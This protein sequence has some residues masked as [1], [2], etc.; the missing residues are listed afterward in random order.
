MLWAFEKCFG[1]TCEVHGWSLPEVDQSHFQWSGWL[2]VLPRAFWQCCALHSLVQSQEEDCKFDENC[3]QQ[4]QPF[5]RGFDL[6]CCPSD[7]AGLQFW[8]RTLPWES[9][10][11][12]NSP[13]ISCPL[14]L[15]CCPRESKGHPKYMFVCIGS[16]HLGK[17]F[18]G[19]VQSSR[20]MCVK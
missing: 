2:A 18:C 3:Q 19:V 12:K 4:F 14:L 11:V 16:A 9:Y 15:F 8:F 1:W 7:V 20:G 6:D 10:F 13:S 17:P 5:C